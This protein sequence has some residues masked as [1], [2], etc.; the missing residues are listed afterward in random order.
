MG[1][2]INGSTGGGGGEPGSLYLTDIFYVADIPAR[3]A[4][5]TGSGTGEVG[6]G[7]IVVVAD[8]DGNG[9]TKRYVWDGTQ[10]APLNN[11]AAD[12]FFDN[13]TTALTS[14]DVQAA[15]E[16][17]YGSLGSSGIFATVGPTNGA[18]TSVSAALSAGETHIAIIESIT[19]TA[20]IELPSGRTY[21]YLRPD[22]NWQFDNASLVTTTNTT[23]ARELYIV[24]SGDLTV[25]YSGLLRTW[26]DG[27]GAP[28]VGHTLVLNGVNL[29]NAGSLN[30][31]RLIDGSADTRSIYIIENCRITMGANNTFIR[32]GGHQTMINN[33]VLIGGGGSSYL[34]I[35]NSNGNVT[36]NNIYIEGTW[37][38]TGDIIQINNQS[39]VISNLYFRAQSGYITTLSGM[40]SNIYSHLCKITISG[41]LSN[42]SSNAEIK[43]TSGN[44]SNVLFSTNGSLNTTTTYAKISHCRFINSLVTVYGT[45][46]IYEGIIYEGGITT[47]TTSARNKFNSC[48]FGTL[49]TTAVTIQSPDD[50]FDLCNFIRDVSVASTASGT[51]FNQCTFDGAITVDGSN[52]LFANCTFNGTVTINGAD[53]RFIDCTFASTVTDNGTG[54]SITFSTN[55]IK[56]VTNADSPYT[57]QLGDNVLLCDAS[58]GAITV[59]L[60]SIIG[61][62]EIPLVVKKID[63]FTNAVTI[64]GTIDGQ[65]NLLLSSQNASVRLITSGGSAYVV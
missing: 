39:A 35:Q 46:N 22:V 2:Y 11:T 19:E 7:D 24:G 12:V 18:Y 17:I 43:L 49:N 55:T 5:P 31:G 3:D 1:I 36:L 60:A 33:V 41:S 34:A 29:V 64:S 9:N 48:S 14:V 65:A 28:G 50:R 59:D 44:L 45:D 8:A 6:Q 54:T 15:I 58:G 26:F 37:A 30:Y 51:E 27:S 38:S 21:I 56:V 32:A 10:Y 13:S 62:D 42:V 61:Y 52:I 40:C 4:L 16:E 20:D 57:V 63:S 53:A 25:N 23:I 47:A